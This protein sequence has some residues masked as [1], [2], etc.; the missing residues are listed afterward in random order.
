MRGRWGQWWR[1]QNEKVMLNSEIC[2]VEAVE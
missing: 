2:R 1:E